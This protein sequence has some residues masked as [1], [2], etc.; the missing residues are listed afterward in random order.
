MMGG[1]LLKRGVLP[2]H[3]DQYEDAELE[4]WVGQLV[5]EQVQEDPRQV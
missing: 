2:K 4:A 3:P 5:N 1:G